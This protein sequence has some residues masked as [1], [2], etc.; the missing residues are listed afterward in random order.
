V[1]GTAGTVA[2][3]IATSEV[4]TGSLTYTALPTPGPSVTVDVPASGKVLLS[5]ASGMAGSPGGSSC[6]MSYALSG[7]NTQAASDST[8]VVLGGGNG[9]FLRA[10]AASVFNGLTPGSTTFTALYKVNAANVSCTYSNRT[11]ILI[12]LP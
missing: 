11:I 3:S 10:S 1:P 5:V 2:E 6:F 4:L 7:A 12:P 9:Q 8:A